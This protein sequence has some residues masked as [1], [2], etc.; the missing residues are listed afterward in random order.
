M[1]AWRI[2]AILAL[3][4]ALAAT[5]CAHAPPL[6]VRTVAIAPVDAMGIP[7]EEGEALRAAIE[8]QLATATAHHSVE[9][10]KLAPLDPGDAH[11]R[12]SEACLA[13]AGKRVPADLVLS[14]TVAGL[15]PT[16]LV[17]SRLI[18][19]DNGL[20]LQD[21]QET[22]TGGPQALD[23][24]ARSLAQRLFPEPELRTP[25]YG[26]WWV[27]TVAGVVAAGAGT[28]AAVLA[29]RGRQNAGVIHIGD[30]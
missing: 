19:T 30:L 13:E 11:C 29:T 10:E 1:R 28:T 2:A 4:L 27:W 5:G 22:L 21:L 15:G 14:L 3:A 12:E 26:K 17:R 8:R 25:W 16:R 23:P 6:Q 9:R 7:T 24:Y 18:G 20:V